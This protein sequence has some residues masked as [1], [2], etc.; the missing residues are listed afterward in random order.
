M[1][2]QLLLP[3]AHHRC[4]MVGVVS[5]CTADGGVLQPLCLLQGAVQASS[6][7]R[8][9]LRSSLHGQARCQAA[10][11]GTDCCRRQTL[12]QAALLCTAALMSRYRI[13]VAHAELPSQ[14]GMPDTGCCRCRAD[15]AQPPPDHK[16][17][18]DKDCVAQLDSYPS[19]TLKSGVKIVD[20]RTGTGASPPVG[21]QVVV[22]YGA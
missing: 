19:Q 1:A 6:T 10:T 21:L 18:C 13:G 8:R 4:P 15:A 5:Q 16:L 2:G 17:L 9:P 22:N 14:Q 12:S 20:V 11:E 7:S 3:A